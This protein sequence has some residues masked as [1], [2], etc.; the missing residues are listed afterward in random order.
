MPEGYG[1]AFVRGRADNLLRA[2]NSMEDAMEQALC[3]SFDHFPEI[4]V[5]PMCDQDRQW[6]SMDIALA[7]AAAEAATELRQESIDWREALA[8]GEIVK[9]KG[10]GRAAFNRPSPDEES[11]NE[12]SLDEEEEEEEAIPSSNFTAFSGKGN[13]LSD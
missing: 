6:G 9:G 1:K 12:E 7:R 4:W 2:G 8:C 3:E 10:K 5:V 13:R 11:S